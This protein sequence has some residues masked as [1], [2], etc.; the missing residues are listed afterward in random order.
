V[1]QPGRKLRVTAYAVTAVVVSAG[2][3]ALHATGALNPLELQTVDARFDARGTQPKPADVAVVAI[4]ATTFSETGQQFPF[5][6]SMH[7][8]VID[9]LRADGAK[10]IAYDVQFTEQTEP[11]EDNALLGAVSKARP[12]LLSTTE[13]GPGGSTNVF[14]GD[15]TVRSVGARVGNTGLSA[16]SRGVNRTVAYSVDGLPSFAVVAAQLARAHGARGADPGRDAYTLPGHRAWID[17][18]GPPGSIL[19]VPFSR[20]LAGK[21]KKGTFRGRTVV[22]GASAPSLQDVHPTST[23][24]GDA[25]MSG[26]EIQAAAIE[27]VRRGLPLRSVRGGFAW[28]LIVLMA[29]AVPLVA[30]RLRFLFVVLFAIAV[31]VAYPLAA[32][33]LFSAGWVVPVAVPLLALAVATLGTSAGHALLSAAE[34]IRTRDL[35]ARFVPEAVVDDVLARTDGDLRLG[36]Q[37]REGTVMFCDLRGFTTFSEDLEPD[38]VIDVLNQYFTEMTGA[39]MARQGTLVA[40]LGDGILAVFGAP[41]EQADHA[42]RALEAARDM[43]FDRLPRL[44]AALA[45]QG[46][47][48]E[49]RIGVGLHSGPVVSGNVGSPQRIE[50]AAIGDTTNTASRVEGMTKVEGEQLLLSGATLDALTAAASRRGL[51]EVGQREVR[52]R[53]HG[54]ALW[55]V[56]DVDRA[57]GAGAD[58][59]SAAVVDGAAGAS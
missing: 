17:Y 1:L 24:T 2:A 10:V 18:P 54:I 25:L 31:A 53:K 44:N 14:G 49:F 32:A 38:R 16:D 34:R 27:T 22:V 40:Y 3:L 45:E 55:S 5:P 39:I 50:Y 7:A 8:K 4:D 9:R 19:T 29:S 41:L 37:R 52:G 42:D 46:I 6:R 12:V 57:P 59:A 28:L 13:V 48:H 33:L 56:D 47:D 35:F 51:R 36:G 26:P 23:T 43:V 11:A 20:V 15:E 21:F 58:G 30:M